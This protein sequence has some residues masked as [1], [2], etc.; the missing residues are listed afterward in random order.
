MNNSNSNRIECRKTERK[1]KKTKPFINR[2]AAKVTIQHTKTFLQSLHTISLTSKLFCCFCCCCCFLFLFFCLSDEII[3]NVSL[4]FFVVL[5]VLL[6]HWNISIIVVAVA[7]V[8]FL[9]NSPCYCWIAV[10]SI[11]RVLTI[12]ICKLLVESWNNER[13][14]EVWLIW[15]LEWVVFL[16]TERSTIAWNVTCKVWIWNSV[17]QLFDLCVRL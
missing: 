10:L 4:F 15:H 1:G 14:N 13:I 12:L 17:Q 8:F 2:K 3:E 16:I 6:S 5:A 9:F 11:W 7:I